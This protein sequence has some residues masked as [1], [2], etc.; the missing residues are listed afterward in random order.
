MSMTGT[1]KPKVAS[2]VDE[3]S[4][5]SADVWAS[6]DQTFTVPSKEL[7]NIRADESVP[8]PRCIEVSGRVWSER[9]NIG[10]GT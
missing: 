6:I 2:K 5:E 7:E 4:V 3:G 10:I 1:G 9:V 8:N